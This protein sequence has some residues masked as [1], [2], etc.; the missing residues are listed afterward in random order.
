MFKK[1]LYAGA[2]LCTVAAL[3]SCGNK[4]EQTEENAANDTVNVV[5][6][7]VDDTVQ[8]GDTTITEQAQVVAI[9]NPSEAAPAEKQDAKAASKDVKTEEA[10]VATS[11]K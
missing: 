6:V 5:G 7:E 9:E 10:T 11:A 3:S 4:Q 1:V 2:I 8:N